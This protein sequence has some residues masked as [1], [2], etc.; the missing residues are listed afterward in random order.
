[1]L[2]HNLMLYA[3]CGYAGA[4]P[5]PVSMAVMCLSRT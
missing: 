1:M 2:A 5:Q 4:S 3:D